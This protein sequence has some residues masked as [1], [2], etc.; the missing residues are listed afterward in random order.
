MASGGRSKRVHSKKA[1]GTVTAVLVIKTVKNRLH[2]ISLSSFFN[3]S[4]VK[5]YIEHHAYPS[6]RAESSQFHYRND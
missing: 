3:R 6:T 2:N 1:I 4:N 5:I